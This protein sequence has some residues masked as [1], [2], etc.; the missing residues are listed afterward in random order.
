MYWIKLICTQ[1]TLFTSP[2]ML[3]L[4]A[5]Q[6]RR[7]Y[8]SL[9]FKVW[10]VSLNFICS[11]TAYN[12]ESQLFLKWFQIPCKRLKI[13]LSAI[14][15]QVWK[16]NQIISILLTRSCKVYCKHLNSPALV[17]NAFLHHFKSRWWNVCTSWIKLIRKVHEETRSIIAT[18]PWMGCQSIAGS[19]QS[20]T[21]QPC[22]HRFT[23]TKKL[24]NNI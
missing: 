20:T 23:K 21:K 7:W 24:P 14:S 2:L 5:S 11:L 16:T 10:T 1:R 3:F 4:R 8:A 15:S 13:R 22:L 17:F 19:T 9:K 18:L 12:N 6:L